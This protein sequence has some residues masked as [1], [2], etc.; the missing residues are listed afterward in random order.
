MPTS[1][2]PDHSRIW[3]FGAAAPLTAAQRE[4]L[5]ADLAG[6]VRGW[7]AHGSA[8]VAGHEI[9]EDAFVIVA[10]DETA[11]GASG[12]SIDAMV[13]HLGELEGRLG[14]ELLD[15]SRIWYRTGGGGIVSCDRAEFGSLSEQGDIDAATPVFDPTIE[16]L[17]ELRA[18]RLERSAGRSWHARLLRLPGSAPA[19]D[20]APDPSPD[21]DLSPAS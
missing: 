1:G 12:C 15:G 19:P 5:D 3:V 4:T 16:T 2:L 7:A 8:L 17:G 21:R 14:I 20:P 10:V 6:F 18:G 13:R 11:Q 9:V